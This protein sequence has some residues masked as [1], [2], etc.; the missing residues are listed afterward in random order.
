M[1]EYRRLTGI[2][3]PALPMMALAACLSFFTVASSI[4]LL[5]LSA[6]LIST[7]ALHPP[8]AALAVSIT[9]VRFFGISR[10]ICRYGERY[11]SHKATFQILYEL[12]VWF[13]RTLEELSL[14]NLFR[15][16]SGDL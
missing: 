14:Y 15:Y 11:V 1:T 3:K 16:R 2:I 7:A 4:G 10:A 12:R 8:L 5:S 9:G 13:Y 6:H